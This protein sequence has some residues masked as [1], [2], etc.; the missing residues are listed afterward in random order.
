ML[1]RCDMPEGGQCPNGVYWGFI[2]GQSKTDRIEWFARIQFRV[3]GK[4]QMKRDWNWR[5]QERLQHRYATAML[6]GFVSTR[7]GVSRFK[8]RAYVRWFWAPKED[9]WA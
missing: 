1:G 6:A 4:P 5:D 2:T 3:P 9:M 8:P 7:F